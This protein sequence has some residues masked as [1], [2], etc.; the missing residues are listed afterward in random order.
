MHAATN[1]APGS[2]ANAGIDV[3]FSPKIRQLLSDLEALGCDAKGVPHK[4]VVFSSHKSAV[5]HLHFVLSLA[6]V[7]HVTICA[8]DKI[9]DQ[10]RA[11]ATWTTQPECKVFLLHAGAA[12]AGLTLVAAHAVFLMEPFTTPGQELQ[13][14]NR[15]HRI[16]QQHAVQCVTYYCE[17]TVEER[18]LA[19]RRLEGDSW[20]QTDQQRA[21]G[22]ADMV[23]VPAQSS[24]A[25]SLA[26]SGLTSERLRFVFGMLDDDGSVEQS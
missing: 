12:A 18:L 11:V 17:R 26:A 13:A 16:G 15:C 25:S 9:G 2:R 19:L 3:R 5:H 8:G 24:G 22:E 21:E 4:A 1:V 20:H 7:P 10:Q 14:M 23:A 6:G